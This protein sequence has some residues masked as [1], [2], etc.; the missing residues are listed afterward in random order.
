MQEAA[1]V[2]TG[3]DMTRPIC[4]LSAEYYTAI[5]DLGKDRGLWTFLQGSHG[6]V[7]LENMT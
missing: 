5:R 4:D 7:S 6:L 3:A 2:I 1:R